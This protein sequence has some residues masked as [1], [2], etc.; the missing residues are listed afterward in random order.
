MS[1]ERV[2]EIRELHKRLVAPAQDGADTEQT[3]SWLGLT[4]KVPSE[5]MTPC[6]VSPLFG[7]AVADEVKEGDRVLD[8][9]AGSGAHG[10]AAAHKAAEVIAVDISPYAVAAVRA[11][12]ELN[13]VGDRVK[14][15]QSDIFENVEGLFDLIIFNPPF[16]WFPARNVAEAATTDENYAALT[17]FFREARGHLADGG[18]MMI[19]FSTVGDIDYLRKLMR[20]A[21]FRQE[22]VF[23]HSG[24]FAGMPADYFTYRL[25]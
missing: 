24:D 18:R 15:H 3:V 20:D 25:S 16:H 5:V 17:R 7:K 1:D 13:N 14:A 21:G 23:Q 9:G 12:A 11:N 19:F 6:A 4:L 10:I 8:M 2:E 22:L